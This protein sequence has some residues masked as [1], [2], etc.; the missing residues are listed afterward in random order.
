[1]ALYRLMF[2]TI[3]SQG[4][5][6]S[7]QG[8]VEPVPIEILPAGKSLDACAAIKEERQRKGDREGRKRKRKKKISDFDKKSSA[9]DQ[10]F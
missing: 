7:N 3:S 6:K 5:G 9:T 4:L 1:M 10:V 2:P 8:R